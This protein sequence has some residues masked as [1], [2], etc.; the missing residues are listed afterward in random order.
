MKTD[1]I[2]FGP[3]VP[4]LFQIA[5]FFEEFFPSSGVKQSTPLANH[6]PFAEFMVN[7][8]KLMNLLKSGKAESRSGAGTAEKSQPPAKRTARTS[9]L[10]KPEGNGDGK[11]NGCSLHPLKKVEF[12]FKSPSANSVKLAGDFTEWEKFPVD[13]MH[14]ADGVWFTV[15][16]LVPGSY[17]YRFIVDGCWCDDPRSALHAPN[18]FGTKNAIIHVA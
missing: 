7:P 3:S 4:S 9:T 17:S 15:V 18:P 8:E 10:R 2:S 6:L 11:T 1:S 13:M 5:T 14:S 12:T 16:P